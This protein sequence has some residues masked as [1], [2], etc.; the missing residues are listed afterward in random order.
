MIIQRKGLM[1]H[2]KSEPKKVS[3][4]A[5]IRNRY[6]EVK[7]LTQYTNG[8]VTNSQLDQ[9]TRAKRSALSQQATTRHI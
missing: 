4:G 3:K 8:K 2:R 7:H 5:N 1:T 9:Q 6:N